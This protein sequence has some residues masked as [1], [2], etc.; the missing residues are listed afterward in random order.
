MSIS[1]NI[2]AI[3]FAILF[4]IFYLSLIQ[5]LIFRHDP[6]LLVPVINRAGGVFT[7]TGTIVHDDAGD[8]AGSFTRTTDAYDDKITT[9]FFRDN[10]ESYAIGSH[11]PTGFEDYGEGASCDL[12]VVSSPVYEGSRALKFYDNGTSA[13]AWAEKRFGSSIDGHSYRRLLYFRYNVATGTFALH[14]RTSAATYCMRWRVDKA[15]N[16]LYYR[17]NGG[18][19]EYKS[20]LSTGTWYKLELWFDADSNMFDFYVDDS[21]EA[22][23]VSEDRGGHQWFHHITDYGDAGGQTDYVD[24]VQFWYE[25]GTYESQ[26]VDVGAGVDWGQITWDENLDGGTIVVKVKTSPDGADWSESWQT[27]SNGDYITGNQRYLKYRIEFSDARAYTTITNI[28]I[29]YSV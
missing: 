24:L 13:S 20:G 7:P 25:N 2:A 4:W 21:L 17:N 14:I 15:N 26:N 29:T 27:V 5:F 19:V 22:A 10:I 3:E 8:F 18:W 16:K 11:D 1:V 23:N 9:I 6:S 28:R 12:I